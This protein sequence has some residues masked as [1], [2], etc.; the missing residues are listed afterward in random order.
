MSIYIELLYCARSAQCAQL[1]SN[2][3]YAVAI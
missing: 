2:S 3:S 1:V